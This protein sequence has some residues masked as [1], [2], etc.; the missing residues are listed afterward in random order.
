MTHKIRTEDEWFA[1]HER[2]LIEDIKRERQRRELQLAE[3]LKQEEAQKRKALHWM[4]CSKCGSDLAEDPHYENVRI[5]RCTRC[6]GMF[7][8]RGE[9]EEVLLNPLEEKKT[10]R[11]GILH[12]VLPSW[13]SKDFDRSKVLEDFRIDQERRKKDVDNW[14]ATKEGADAR[15]NHWMKCPKCGSDMQEI[16]ISYGLH[17]DDC[18]VCG[19]IYLDFGELE[20]IGAL[21]DEERKTIRDRILSLSIPHNE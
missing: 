4:K 10:L 5:D 20:T 21:T 13:L 7:F 14:L 1:K 8:D 3:M 15:T 17:L 12:L 19:G 18:T 9:L 16:D 6:G 2:T 11:I